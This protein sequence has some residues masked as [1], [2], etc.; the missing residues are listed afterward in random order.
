MQSKRSFFNPTLFRKNLSR[1]WPLWGGVTALGALVPLYLL[2]HLLQYPKT[3]LDGLDMAELLYNAAVYFVPAFSFGYAILVAMVVWGYLYSARSVGM[4][5]TLPVDRTGLFITGAASGLAMM[6]IPYV[7]VG[8]LLVVLSLAW[9]FFSATAVVNTILAVLLMT[10]LF[11]GMATFCAM[12]TGNIFALPAFYLILNF[13]APALDFLI[14]TLARSFIVGLRNDYSGAVEFLSPLVEIYQNFGVDTNYTYDAMGEYVSR[15]VTLEGLGTVAIYGLVGLVLLG[16]GWLLY[17][18]RSS[19]SAGD[20]VAFRWLRPVFR[21]GV[22]LV[23]A[24]TTGQALYNLFWRGIFYTGEYAQALPMAVCMA[25]MGVVG[26][27]AASMLLE[28][29]LRVFRKNWIGAI[30]TV[31]VCAAVCFAVEAD[32][33]GVESRVPELDEIEYVTMSGGNYLYD[34]PALYADEDPELVERVRALHLAIIADLDRVVEDSYAVFETRDDGSGPWYEY[35]YVRL[36]YKLKSG[37]WVERAYNLYLLRDKWQAG[38]SYEGAFKALIAGSELQLNLVEGSK[39]SKLESVF[40]YNY[41]VGEQVE[42]FDE[43]AVWQAILAD[44]AAGNIYD[45]DPFDEYY[46]EA[47]PIN[48]DL[49]YRIPGQRN[50]Y[51]YNYRSIDLRPTMTNA[52]RV[53][54]EQ[55][56]IT[57]EDVEEWNEDMGYKAE[58]AAAE[59]R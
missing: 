39:N 58:T 52:V 36:E 44:A 55:G 16:L 29:T 1:S 25:I 14:M 26:Y 4:M 9:G 21:F 8:G 38:E 5:H 53:L 19:E 50:E 6:L 18:L 45:Y 56:I 3:A 51:S 31:V 17:R 32:F 20:V 28:K 15:T 23:F 59:I 40:I 2:L 48:I 27:F 10:V 47:Y 49:E 41:E 57:A 54:L 13:A 46:N 24:L 43:K 11:F 7:V 37:I 35:Q 12:V 22:A 33:F 30:V 34:Q 42:E